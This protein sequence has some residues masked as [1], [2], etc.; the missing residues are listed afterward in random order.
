MV[1]YYYRL[2]GQKNFAQLTSMH[3]VGFE[4]TPTNRIEL[5]STA[6]DH[7]ATDALINN[8]IIIIDVYILMSSQQRDSNSR[9]PVYETDALTTMLC[10]HDIFN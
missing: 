1:Y 4:P 5:E 10:W 6:L 2:R 9:P 3:P 8:S 7:S